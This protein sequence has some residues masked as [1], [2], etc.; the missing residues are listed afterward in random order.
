MKLFIVARNKEVVPHYKKAIKKAGFRYGKKNADM[1]L[2]L[3]GDGTFLIAE[4]KYPRIPKL[5]IRDS[6]ICNKC[7]V[8]LFDKFLLRL[9]NKKNYKIQKQPKIMATY[10]N[11]DFI[12]I[13]DVVI[14]NKDQQHAIRY[15]MKI[16]RKQ[17][18]KEFI[19]DGVVVSTPWGST[20][21]FKSITQKSF[22]K[23]FGVA[24][25]NVQKTKKNT[26]F[27]DKKAKIEIEMTRGDA[28][29]THDNDKKVFLM[30]TGDKITIKKLGKPAKIVVFKK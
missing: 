23:G 21:Y 30:K 28:L 13:N 9:K 15:T 10:K 20:G 18:G 2:S 11:S 3:G 14:R 22:E 16:D 5:L 8:D 7:S 25:N 29:V 1:I 27:L 12:A 4:H 6:K 19:G 26:Y 17:V 24:L